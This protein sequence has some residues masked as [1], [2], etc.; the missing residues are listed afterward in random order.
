MRNFE[1]W[2]QGMRTTPDLTPPLSKLSHH[3]NKDEE[4]PIN[5]EGYNFLGNSIG[6]L[7]QQEFNPKKKTVGIPGAGF[8]LPEIIFLSLR[9]WKTSYNCHLKSIPDIPNRVKG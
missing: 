4:R 9:W 1:L 3:A 2:L 8:P 7:L 6:R 5:D